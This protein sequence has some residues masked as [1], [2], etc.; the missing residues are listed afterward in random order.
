MKE[1]LASIKKKS[2]EEVA[3]IKTK[4]DAVEATQAQ[5]DKDYEVLL[6]RA[7]DND[8]T[9][10]HMM[11]LFGANNNSVGNYRGFCCEAA[12]GRMSFWC[13]TSSYI[14]GGLSFMEPFCCELVVILMNL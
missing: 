3:A 13:E 2:A 5:R 10:A 14:L 9:V 8:A 4:A 11:A 1:E 6:T 12:A 7:E